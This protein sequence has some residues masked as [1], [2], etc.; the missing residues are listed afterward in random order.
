M[1]S[2]SESAVLRTTIVCERPGVGVIPDAKAKAGLPGRNALLPENSALR[3][4]QT[5]GRVEKKPG[6]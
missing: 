5:R 3:S 2:N 1:E 4:P 6:Q